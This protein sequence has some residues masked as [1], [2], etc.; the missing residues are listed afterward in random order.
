MQMPAIVLNPELNAMMAPART[1]TSK[2]GDDSAKHSMWTGIG[3][4]SIHPPLSLR[5][6]RK[7]SV[8]DIE[9]CRDNDPPKYA[10]KL[11]KGPG[12]ACTKANPVRKSAWDTHPVA[13]TSFCSSGRTTWQTCSS[14]LR[15]TLGDEGRSTYV[16]AKQLQLLRELA[17]QSRHW[18]APSTAAAS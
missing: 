13:T 6:V 2:V 10:A 7:S 9:L 4:S 12:M 18:H 5:V 16:N 17:W 3:N 11:N 8:I 1:P 14:S 15:A